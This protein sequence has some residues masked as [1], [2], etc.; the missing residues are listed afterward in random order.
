VLYPLLNNDEFLPHLVDLLYHVL[1]DEVFAIDLISK[2]LDVLDVVVGAA[3]REDLLITRTLITVNGN[4]VDFADIDVSNGVIH[5]IDVVLLPSWVSNSIS[6]RVVADSGLSTLLAL[7]SL[8]ALGG[9]LAGPGELTLVA[10]NES[11]HRYDTQDKAT[12]VGLHPQ[13]S[14]SS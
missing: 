14:A 4:K 9:A 13:C 3:N 6:D 7:F 12:N 10:P 8:A 2:E 11:S 1:P 5:I